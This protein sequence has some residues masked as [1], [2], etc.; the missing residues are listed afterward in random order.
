M[1]AI[2]IIPTHKRT[3]SVRVARVLDGIMDTVILAQGTKISPTQCSA[4]IIERPCDGLCANRNA[5]VEYALR[6]GCDIMFQIDDDVNYPLITV[7]AMLEI[8]ET[9][10]KIAAVCAES[11]TQAFWNKKVSSNKPFIM[12][13]VA[14]ALWAI[15]TSVLEDVISAFGKPAFECETMEDIHLSM[16]LWTMGYPIVKLHGDTRLCYS[17][18]VPRLKKTDEQG[19]QSIS[20]RNA[21]MPKAVEKLQEFVGTDKVLQRCEYSTDDNGNLSYHIN[22]NYRV[23]MNNSYKRNGNIGYVDNKGRML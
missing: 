15:R 4:T 16:K 13:P 22:Y 17:T 9:E 5:G 14:S 3:S 6:D 20:E 10:H 11:A 23:M 2:A 21:H 18:F 12:A 7:L 8:F 1:I 19:G